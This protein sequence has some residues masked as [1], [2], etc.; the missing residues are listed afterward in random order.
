MTHQPPSAL[1]VALDDLYVAGYEVGR[2]R[3]GEENPRL[4][5]VRSLAETQLELALDARDLVR[6]VD[7]LP[8]DE[9]PFGWDVPDFPPGIESERS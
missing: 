3:R 6:I 7:A 4:G 2:A 8:P 1:R 5:R 9:R